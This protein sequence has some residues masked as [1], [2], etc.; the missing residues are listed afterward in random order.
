MADEKATLLE[1]MAQYLSV[2]ETEKLVNA[3]KRALEIGVSPPEM[4]IALSKG[5]TIVGQKFEAKEYFIPDLLMAAET[6]NAAMEVLQ[7]HLAVG[8]AAATGKAVIG[9]VKDDI[10][11]I[12]KNILVNFMKSAGFEVHD[13]GVDVQTE[14][15]VEAVKNTN[16]DILGMSCLMSTTMT[17]IPLVID[18]IK[19]AGLRDKVRIIL[20]GAPI[21]EEYGKSVGAD[22]VTNDAVQGVRIMEQ[23]MKEKH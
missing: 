15:F 14:G 20:G 18:A 19:A 11:D 23:W 2:F 12:G 22:G 16:A 21:T 13:I 1:Q 3:V 9:T 10:H 8:K 5:M 6:M 7:P 4:V 17:A